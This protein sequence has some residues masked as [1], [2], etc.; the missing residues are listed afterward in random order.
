MNARLLQFTRRYVMYM[1]V[2]LTKKKVEPSY[3][4]TSILKD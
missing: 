1:R 4:Q 3:Y 2:L